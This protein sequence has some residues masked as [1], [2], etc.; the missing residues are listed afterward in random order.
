MTLEQATT[1]YDLLEVSPDTSPQEVRAA[2]M[3]AKSAYRK[4]SVALYTLFNKEET[5]EILKRIEEAYQILSNPEKRRQYDHEHGILTKAGTE[6]P[7]QITSSSLNLS[8]VNIDKKIVSID[9]VPPMEKIDNAFE[10]L[11]P[12]P[13]DFCNPPKKPGTLPLP[14]TSQNPEQD[15]KSETE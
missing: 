4:E 1:Y 10:L 6:F 9:R 8:P 15:L 13:T 14:S 12:P 7:A 11:V 3:R 5:E 2:Y